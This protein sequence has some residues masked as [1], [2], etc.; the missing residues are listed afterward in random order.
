MAITTTDAKQSM[1]I[2]VKASLRRVSGDTA[3]A[4]ARGGGGGKKEY[5]R[6]S[7]QSLA[8]NDEKV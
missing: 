4:T 8:V 7:K 1:G 2:K 5:S 3:S 6:S